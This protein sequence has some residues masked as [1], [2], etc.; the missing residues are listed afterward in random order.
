MNVFKPRKLVIATQNRGKLR[1]FA[2]MLKGLQVEL[3]SLS[4]F[5][6][7]KLPPEDAPTYA[8]NALSKARAAAAAT[9]LPSLGDDSGLEVDA[10]DG[11]PGIYSAR[12]AGPG[13]GDRANNDKLLQL[14]DGVSWERRTARFRCLIALVCPSRSG[15]EKDIVGDCSETLVEGVCEGQIA[16]APSGERGFGYDPLFYLTDYG[17]TIAE[18]PEDVKN[19]IS[20]RGRAVAKIEPL[21]KEIFGYHG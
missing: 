14:L 16:H 8:G 9:G 6:G 12:F 18:V 21:L 1:E 10:L 15:E 13:A 11:R 3:L 17:C 19:Q 4:D 20:H 7:L 2:G 5:P